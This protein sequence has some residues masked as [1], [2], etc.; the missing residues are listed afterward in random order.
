MM[1]MFPKVV[2]DCLVQEIPHLEVSPDDPSVN[3]REQLLI[4]ILEQG[5]MNV[6]MGGSASSVLDETGKVLFDSLGTALWTSAAQT[7]CEPSELL[8]TKV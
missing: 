1:E 7:T 5:I 4:S 2:S 8:N 6:S 3:I